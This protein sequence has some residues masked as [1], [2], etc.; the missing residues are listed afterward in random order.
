MTHIHQQLAEGGWHKLSLT[1]QMANIGSEI[2]RALRWQAK[3]DKEMMEKALDRGL[4]LFDLTIGDYR[5]E[6]RLKEICR[7]REVVGDYFFGKNSYHS[8]SE[9]LEKYFFYFALAGRLDL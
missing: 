7:M 8:T 2:T 4:E 1:E 5:W 3:G 9:S 6:R